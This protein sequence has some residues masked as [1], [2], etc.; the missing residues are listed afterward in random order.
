MKLTVDL[1]WKTFMHDWNLLT[2]T[3][4]NMEV[5]YWYDMI[6]N[7]PFIILCV[8]DI[9]I[10][11]HSY[12]LVP[13]WSS[14]LC[15]PR[16]SKVPHAKIFPWTSWLLASAIVSTVPLPTYS[17]TATRLSQLSTAQH[18]ELLPNILTHPA[19]SFNSFVVIRI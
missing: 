16:T 5:N 14:C 1:I 18:R 19:F 3:E 6:S 17:G 15:P 7:F 13:A 4:C 11:P 2:D 9:R 8:D 10:S 12:W